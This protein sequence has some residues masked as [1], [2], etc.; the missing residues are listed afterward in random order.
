MGFLLVLNFEKRK[1]TI[2]FPK[3][4]AR[5]LLGLFTHLSNTGTLKEYKPQRS[6]YSVSPG[7][8]VPGLDIQTSASLSPPRPKSTFAPA[9]PSVLQGGEAPPPS[10]SQSECGAHRGFLPVVPQSRSIGWVEEAVENRA[11]TQ[12]KPLLA[13]E[14]SW[15]PLGALVSL[16]ASGK[17]P[18][19]P[20]SAVR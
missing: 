10:P 15:Y 11:Q 12:K 13:R 9:A 5:N 4:T 14:N 6:L 16:G 18:C 17:W 8:E 3:K 20:D 7:N 19:R 2:F 1:K